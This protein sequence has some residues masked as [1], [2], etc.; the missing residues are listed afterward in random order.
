MSDKIDINKFANNKNPEI[1]HKALDAYYDSLNI[2]LL[3]KLWGKKEHAI[4][5]II[6]L[7]LFV[8]VITLVG[9]LFCGTETASLSKKDVLTVLLPTITTI[10]GYLV[11]KYK[12]E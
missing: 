11:G 10:V 9:F 12:A 6:G 3:G 5:N 2:G 4:H 7:V 8:F 1:A